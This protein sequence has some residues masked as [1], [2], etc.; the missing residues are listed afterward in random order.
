MVP[1]NS[2]QVDIVRQEYSSLLYKLG[3]TTCAN[4]GLSNRECPVID[5]HKTP[6][7]IKK[8]DEDLNC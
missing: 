5:E 3:F 6:T 2:S 7:V 1:L 4:L 8:E